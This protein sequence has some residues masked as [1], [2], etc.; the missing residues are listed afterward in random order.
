MPEQ[1]LSTDEYKNVQPESVLKTSISM[2]DYPQGKIFS[3]QDIEKMSQEIFEK[4]EPVIMQQ[5]QDGS[6]F[7]QSNAID[8]S[9][10]KNPL[11][12]SSKIYTREDI[13]NMTNQEFSENE[14]EINSQLNTIGTPSQ[15]ELEATIASGT[16]GLIYVEP[17]TRNDGTHVRGYYRSA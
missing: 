16:A 5:V 14:K 8:Y 9:G 13:N 11:S 15:S 17:Y 6:I 4:Y 7:K 12:E 1:A 3:P 2:T 10:Y